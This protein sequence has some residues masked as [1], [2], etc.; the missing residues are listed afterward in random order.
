MRTS[1][2]R[3][4]GG[5][6]RTLGRDPAFYA[7]FLAGTLG[8]AVYYAY[9]IVL[10]VA[11]TNGHGVPASVWGALAALNAVTVT[12]FQLRVTRRT[13]SLTP[14]QKIGAGLLLMGVSFLLL[15]LGTGL[16][17]LVAFA[18]VFVVGEMLWAPASQA[19]RA[20]LAPPDIRGAYLGALAAG[21]FVANGVAPAA[22]FQVRAGAGEAVL[23]LV[24]LVT[25]AAAAAFYALACR[26]PR[27]EVDLPREHPIAA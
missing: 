19:L 4:V 9:E 11:L 14:A 27:A 1:R 7:L 25:S 6:W 10:P 16:A 8:W 23:W 5:A 17:L 3:R 18:L 21:T 12:F 2:D 20:E 15:T 13:A 22:G 24:I 26:T